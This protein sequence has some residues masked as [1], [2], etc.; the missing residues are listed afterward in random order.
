MAR[1]PPPV[2]P[3]EVSVYL[4]LFRSFAVEYLFF[5]F[6]EMLIADQYSHFCCTGARGSKWPAR[7]G[8]MRLRQKRR[9][10]RTGGGR[11][12]GGAYIDDWGN[13]TRGGVRESRKDMY[14]HGHRPPRPKHRVS[15]W[16]KRI[17]A[18][19]FTT[20]KTTL[21][22]HVWPL[23]WLDLSPFDFFELSFCFNLLARTNSYP[24]CY[25]YMWDKSYS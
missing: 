11:V 7:R 8:K 19:T 1:H 12:H 18:N 24:L 14:P 9:G 5:W 23:F 20:S 22:K 13:E 10:K 6:N 3:I 2:P 4:R 25:E 21:Y 17:F 15:Y 16:L